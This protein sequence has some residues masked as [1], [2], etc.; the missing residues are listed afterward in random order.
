MNVR[1]VV[2]RLAGRAGLCDD[3][4]LDH[5]GAAPDVEGPQM[6][7]RHLVVARRD[8]HGETVRRHAAGECDLAG[9][10]RSYR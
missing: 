6:S 8:G 5:T 3:I 2:F 4:A 7:K 1:N 9:N 10:R